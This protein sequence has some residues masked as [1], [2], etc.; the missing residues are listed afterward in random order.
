MTGPYEKRYHGS[1]FGVVMLAALLRVCV[2]RKALRHRDEARLIFAT[3]ASVNDS[4]DENG[5]RWDALSL[6]P[7]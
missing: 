4:G 5:G 3:I 6:V 1:S 7:A 2:V